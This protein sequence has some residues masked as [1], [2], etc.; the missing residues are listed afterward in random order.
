MI[1]VSVIVPIYNSVNYIEHCICS[2]FEQ[3][4][5][6]IEYIFVDDA[7]TDNS[8]E[9]IKDLLLRYPDRASRCQFI[10]N[11][12]NQGVSTSRNR[13]LSIAQGEYVY[14]CDNDDW[15]SPNMLQSMYSYAQLEN[16]DLVLCDPIAVYSN[17]REE[18]I[19]IVYPKTDRIIALRKYISSVWNP[20]WNML[21]KRNLFQNNGITFPDGKNMCEDYNVSTKLL[22]KAAKPIHCQKAYYYY[23]RANSSSFLSRQDKNANRMKIEVN[24]DLI[25]FFKQEGVYSTYKKELCWR[26]LNA[27]QELSFEPASYDEFLAIVP[28][29]HK[30]ILSCPYL[31]WKV[32]LNMWCLTRK[33]RLIAQFF[34]FCQK[35]KHET[36]V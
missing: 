1:K 9:K 36:R 27:K 32:K 22:L 35:L 11:K 2:L 10:C 8:I 4:F 7:S 24:I 25:N 31:N 26:L 3:T 21:I 34:S 19:P 5:N 15:I 28:E 23:N 29:S 18:R 13:G 20:I 12:K 33:L 14:F 16:S 17:G 6:D 30:Y